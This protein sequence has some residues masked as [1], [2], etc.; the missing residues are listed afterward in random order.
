MLTRTLF[1]AAAALALG[2]AATAQAA[3]PKPFF[4]PEIVSE[5]VTLADLDLNHHAGAATALSRIRNAARRVCGGEPSRWAMNEASL[6]RTCRRDAVDRAVS[7]LD[8][9]LVAALNTRAPA[10]TMV[11][12]R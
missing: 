6:Y 9:P 11:A 1:A 2:L 7:T 4:E 5:K 12:H 8:H 10:R 3:P